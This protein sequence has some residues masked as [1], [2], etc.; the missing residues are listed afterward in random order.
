MISPNKEVATKPILFFYN[1]RRDSV[2]FCK[3]QQYGDKAVAESTA[4]GWALLPAVL[5]ILSSRD[6]VF[7]TEIQEKTIEWMTLDCYR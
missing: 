6:Y 2:C 4:C 3:G 5:K 7:E 1:W